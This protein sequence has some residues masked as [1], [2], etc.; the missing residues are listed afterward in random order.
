MIMVEKYRLKDDEI[1][2]KDR[3]ER[4]VNVLKADI[5]EAILAIEN[6]DKIRAL[7][8]LDTTPIRDPVKLPKFSGKDGEDFHVFKEE[9]ERGFVRNRTPRAAQLSKLRES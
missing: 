1:V 3:V 7:Y 4:E 8:S 2:K 6:E 5:D 9:M